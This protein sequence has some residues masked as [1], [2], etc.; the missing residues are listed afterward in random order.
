M[1]QKLQEIQCVSQITGGVYDTDMEPNGK[2]V[3]AMGMLDFLVAKMPP[4]KVL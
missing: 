1:K 2:K 3:G 4:S